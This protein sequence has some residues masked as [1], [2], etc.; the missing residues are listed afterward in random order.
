MF[1]DL[2]IRDGSIQT[3]TSTCL[4][5]SLTRVGFSFE[6]HIAY[7]RGLG[8]SMVETPQIWLDGRSVSEQNLSFTYRGVTRRFNELENVTDIR[9][10]LGEYA[11]ISVCIPDLTPGQHVLRVNQRLRVSYL[12]ILSESAYERVIIIF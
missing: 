3:L 4:D 6:S 11:T 10:E 9:W 8:L 2:I 1:N 12:P 7:Y 5:K